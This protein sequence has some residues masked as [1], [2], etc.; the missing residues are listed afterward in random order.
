MVYGRSIGA[1]DRLQRARPLLQQAVGRVRR[2]G[3]FE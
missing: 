1:Y 2:V 3:A